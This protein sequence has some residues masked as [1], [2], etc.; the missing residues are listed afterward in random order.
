[1]VDKDKLKT[2]T[3]ITDENRMTREEVDAFLREPHIGR[4]ATVRD[5]GF[6]HLT[7][8]WPMWDGKLLSFALAEE[9]IHIHNLRRDP[10]AT[11][12]VDED[13]R[14]REKRYSAGAAAVAL[15]GE[16]TILDL[17]AS[18]EP[19]GKMF[20]DHAEKYLDG[21]EGD[22]DYWN[23]ETGEHYHVCYLKPAIIVNWD[24]RKFEGA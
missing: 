7:P 23:T 1:M 6:P 24:F 16:V 10:K 19:L 9:R 14:P 4:L 15:R 22:T 11:V 8:V 17:E 2:S 18:E 3:T 21:A 13:W 20:M 5:D 12:L